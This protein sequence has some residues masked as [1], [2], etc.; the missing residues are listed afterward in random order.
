[1]DARRQMLADNHLERIPLDAHWPGS[2]HD[3]NTYKRPQTARTGPSDFVPEPV[4]IHRLCRN[5]GRICARDE[6]RNDPGTVI[7]D[8]V[9][10]GY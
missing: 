2:L 5:R 10:D 7:S 3:L 1:M 6:L 9:T 4:D 8:H